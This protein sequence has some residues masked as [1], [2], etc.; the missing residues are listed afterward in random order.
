MQQPHTDTT[1][2][3]MHRTV[4]GVWH[5]DIHTYRRAVTFVC[6]SS[7]TKSS[8][9][10][11]DLGQA[12]DISRCTGPRYSGT[13]QLAAAGVAAAG[14]PRWPAL[15]A[16]AAPAP[17]ACSPREVFQTPDRSLACMTTLQIDRPHAILSPM[18]EHD[19]HW[20]GG[21]GGGNRQ[22]FKEAIK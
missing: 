5:P 10:E 1:P 9:L 14:H 12:P 4:A 13:A 2:V 18:C 21:G 22:G 8:G 7:Q 17:A 3:G 20:G 11:L 15:S 6:M 19:I 16:Q